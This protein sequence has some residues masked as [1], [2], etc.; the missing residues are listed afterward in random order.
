M[1]GQTAHETT[2]DHPTR[3]MTQRPKTAPDKLQLNAL[4]NI[5]HPQQDVYT[6]RRRVTGHHRFRIAEQ[7][8]TDHPSG[9]RLLEVGGGMAEFSTRLR[10]LG[11]Q[12]TFVDLNP[13]NIHNARKLG[14]ESQQIDL[15]FGLPGIENDQF[16][17][18]VMLEVI[19]HVVNAEHLL[20]E[21]H[22]VLK[23][24]GVLVL[25]TPNFA[26][27]YNRL[28]VL[29]GQLSYDEGYH[30][31]FFTRRSMEHKLRGANLSPVSWRFTSPAFVINR[32][33]KVFLRKPRTHFTVPEF[34][35]SL[36]GQT[37]FVRAVAAV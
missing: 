26:W 6:Q 18:V 21:L 36:L 13:N 33:R 1:S 16:D 37:L 31:R 10:D 27:W 4:V 8:L 28:R 29:L 23:P 9:Q 22:R 20:S 11:Y 12:V 30:Y 7:L 32:L 15:N 5:A 14:F 3:N 19:E 17:A 2:C 34:T 25:S 35:G 24:G